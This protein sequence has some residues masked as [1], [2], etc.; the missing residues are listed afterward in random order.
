MRY[1]LILI[2]LCLTNFLFAQNNFNCSQIG[3]KTYPVRL[4]DIW[5][6]QHSSGTE[7]ALVGVHDG[8]SIVSL[9][10]PSNPTELQFI[11]GG[12]TVWRDL[13]TWNNYLYVCS[14]IVGE[15]LLIA[16][17][18][19][20]PTPVSYQYHYLTVGA[21]T[22][23]NA[24]NIFVDENGYL[25]VTGSD[26]AN[27]AP[28]IFDLNGNPTAPVYLGTVGTE[29]AHDIYVRG[30]TLWGSNV[31]VGEFS[32]FD[33][34][35]KANPQLLATQ[36]T[37]R[38]F[39]HNAWISDNGQTLFTTDERSEAYIDAYDVSDLSDIKLLDKWR[40][41]NA[42]DRQVI[43]H[44]VHVFNDYL[45]TSHY[46]EGVTIIDAKHP[47]NLI[48]TGQFDSYSGT[49][50]GFFGC[51]GAYP[52]LPSG[53]LLIT[54]INTGLYVL[55]PTYLRACRLE[56]IVR[57]QSTT[58][59][60]FDVLVEIENTDNSTNTELS[61]LYK[62]GY[63]QAGNY[64]LKYRK[65]GYLPL[66]TNLDLF[67]DSIVVNDVNLQTA[68]PFHYTGYIRDA[69]TFN[70]IA[71]AKVKYKH[72]A[73]FYEAD[74]F[75]DGFG[76]F[77]F[78]NI[79]EEEYDFIAG[80]WGY[81]TKSERHYIDPSSTPLSIDLDS[82]YYDDFSLDFNWTVS[83][84]MQ[85]GSWE[86]VVPNQ[87]YQWSGMMPKTDLQNDFGKSCF[88]TGENDSRSDAGFSSLKSPVFDGTAI[89]DPYL[90]FHYWLTSFDSTYAVNQDSLEV[91][92]SNGS[93]TSRITYFKN[94]LY[95]W[96]EQKV[97]RLS[98]HIALS[99]NMQIEFIIY[100]GNER[101]FQEA[102]VD[103]IRI[104]NYLA[105]T[106]VE[107]P[108]I[109]ADNSVSLQAYPI[110]FGEETTVSY[111]IPTNLQNSKLYLNI[112]NLYGQLIESYLIPQNS[113]QLNVG[114]SLPKGVYLLQL[115]DQTIK[116]IKN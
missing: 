113:N 93:T 39:T 11:P 66:A 33:V 40:P 17:L 97:Y 90:S 23:K 109:L 49:N 35:N 28:I 111:K 46:T 38:N 6:Y 87:V 55:S 22:I 62:T 42:V 27:G 19:T 1:H 103:R 71:Q 25:Y 34:S 59:P 16:D 104:D 77:N 94:G 57:D 29:Y 26:L 81:M 51:W 91:W 20:L 2:F 73:D 105:I 32:A 84:S 9:S 18:S 112:F 108:Q 88:I 3:H 107:N 8:V 82:A 76:N 75:T 58:N 65:A 78:A 44:N 30:D 53:N 100:N 110:P 4:S 89:G 116:V 61:G 56:G 43:P 69:N 101:N 102:A 64:N 10:T 96:S 86:R 52:Y 63:H 54:D 12:T 5:G 70:G 83:G 14:E 7:Y 115:A 114:R 41:S 45:V 79:L 37:S 85:N 99:N 36:T 68:T 67:N 31:Y 106:N 74:T 21:D 95:N 15:G 80:H 60:I 92:V 48:L 47:D 24:H 50:Q 98:N 72:T 13:K